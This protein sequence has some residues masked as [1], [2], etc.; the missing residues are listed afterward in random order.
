[1][2][3]MV[4][5][6]RFFTSVKAGKYE[7]IPK[8]VNSTWSLNILEHAFHWCLFSQENKQK[9]WKQLEKG[10]QG[11]ADKEQACRIGVLVDM[12]LYLCQVLKRGYHVGN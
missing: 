3:V 9:D 12:S 1:M 10:C 7:N 2:S 8:I 6:R 5:S 4:M 11:K